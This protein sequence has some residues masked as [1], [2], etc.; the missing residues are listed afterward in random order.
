MRHP[1]CCA[2]V[3]RR[4]SGI[5]GHRH[6]GFFE[7]RQ[8]VDGVGIK[9]GVHSVPVQSTGLQP[10]RHPGHL[11]L[12]EGRHSTN[13]AVYQPL[14]PCAGSRSSSTAISS[15]HTKGIGNGAGHKFVGGGDDGHRV[16]RRLVVTHQFECL[17]C[18]CIFA[19]FSPHEI[20]VSSYGICSTLAAQSQ[21]WR[22]A[23]RPPGAFQPGT[24]HKTR[25]FVALE[26]HRVNPAARNG[27]L[28]PGVV[29][30]H[31]HQGV[32]EV[33]QSQ[34]GRTGFDS[35]GWTGRLGWTLT[36]CHCCS[37]TWI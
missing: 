23:H 1:R 27:E 2:T 8:V 20:C 6:V 4:A 31:R 17:R 5:G 3:R 37:P 18:V 15:S 21:Q 33:K 14:P 19:R 11:A 7:Q 25:R 35:C 32:V 12:A 9:G 24:G 22:S 16:T 34:T 29:G 36:G 30:V 28:A 13:G 10:L 26:C